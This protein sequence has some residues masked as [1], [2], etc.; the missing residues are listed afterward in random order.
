MADWDYHRRRR[1]TAGALLANRLS[2]AGRVL[3]LEAGGRDSYIWVHVPVGY[4]YCID[5]PRTDWRFRT[6]AEPGLNGR[7]LLYPRGRILGGCSSI[8]GMI[9]MR[10]QAG[11]Y[12][13][14]RQMGLTGWGWDDV[15]PYFKRTRITPPAPPTPTCTAPGGEWRVENQRLRWEILDDWARAAEAC[16]IPATGDFNTGDNEGVG[17]FKVTQRSGWRWNS[18][19]AFLKPLRGRRT[20]RSAPARRCWGWSSTASAAPA[21]AT[22]AARA[23]RRRAPGPR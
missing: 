2:A 1:R 8:N 13:Q 16:G 9:Y 10:G 18:S 11:D 7:S 3:L 6:R 4:L 22:G 15:L 17:Y 20:W 23:R 12:D 21:C 5:N 19:K 14:W